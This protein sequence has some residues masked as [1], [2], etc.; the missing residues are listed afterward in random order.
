MLLLR[1]EVNLT[2]KSGIG[3][4]TL[5]VAAMVALFA[6]DGFARDPNS[7]GL[8]PPSF[9]I[10]EHDGCQPR[11]GSK[12]GSLPAHVKDNVAEQL[13]KEILSLINDTPSEVQACIWRDRSGSVDWTLDGAK[14][15]ISRC[16]R[17]INLAEQLQKEIG[18]REKQVSELIRSTPSSAVRSC[19]W[20]QLSRS[21]NV[22]LDRARAEISQ[23]QSQMFAGI[24]AGI[25]L[26]AFTVLT[27]RFRAKI[28]AGLYNLFIGCAA[29]LYNLFIG[30][31]ALQLRF[32]RSRKRF[33]DNAIK[34]AEDRLG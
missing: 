15:E 25:V 26:L 7:T 22:T 34:K 8:C 29:G 12:S 19:V 3:N 11:N 27:I 31:L 33:L 2:M 21:G 20:R 28:A 17:D 32:H 10:T 1:V 24:F 23:C 4:F 9:R 5:C 13:Q 16:Q 6:P 30:C 18:Q 14:A